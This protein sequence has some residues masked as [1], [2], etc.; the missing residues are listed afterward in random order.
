MEIILLI[1][2]ILLAA[3]VLWQN[4][5]LQKI[6]NSNENDLAL[7]LLKT[8]LIE[9]NKNLSSMREGFGANLAEFNEKMNSKIDK[10]N[11]EIRSS[12]EKQLSASS[13]IVTD[14]SNRLTK[15]DETNNRVISVADELKTLQNVLQNPKQ[16]GV[17][18]EFYLTQVLAPLLPPTAFPPP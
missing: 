4:S 16:R 15:L 14:V 17:F 7:N 5:K 2:I 6:A 12:L 18:G 3:L 9:M 8:D 1:A 11:L 13:K 10:N